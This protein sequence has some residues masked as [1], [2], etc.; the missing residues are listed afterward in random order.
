M[1]TLIILTLAL[2]QIPPFT[3]RF[4]RVILEEG[5]ADTAR[6]RIYFVAPWRIYYDVDYPVVQ[7]L[8]VVKSTMT[9]WYPEESTGYVIRTKSQ[10]ETPLSQQSIPAIRPEEAMPKLGFKPAGTEV[11]GDSSFS[12]WKPKN[13]K[14]V[15]FDRVVFGYFA[16]VPVLTEV[17]RREG[18]PLM[19]TLFSNHL[20]VDTFNLPTRIEHARFLE[21]GNRTLDIMAYADMDTA[22]AFI[23]S[24][25][26]FT[27]PAYVKLRR[28]NW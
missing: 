7:N 15:P 27:P 11:R 23:D 26:R 19:R 1:N 28:I 3:A 8:T 24:L 20:R 18:T 10:F 4:E 9:I 17:I 14:Q 25:G 22:T 21:D 12:T 13:P 16:G 6:G 2:G 5:V